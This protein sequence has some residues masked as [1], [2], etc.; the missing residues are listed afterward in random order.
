MLCCTIFS[1]PFGI[2]GCSQRQIFCCCVQHE[3]RMQLC[4]EKKKL[5]VCLDVKCTRKT[6]LCE[7]R[8]LPSC[9]LT[10][11]G[12]GTPKRTKPTTTSV[13]VVMLFPLIHTRVEN[14]TAFHISPKAHPHQ[15]RIRPPIRSGTRNLFVWFFF[16]TNSHH[17]RLVFRDESDLSLV[18][19]GH[20]TCANY[21]PLWTSFCVSV[22]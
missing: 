14:P 2:K 17:I 21:S 20:C 13:S 4:A 1:C 12:C 8:M 6:V 11:N 9:G 19:M 5:F 7:F 18:W 3:Q 16:W 22:M 15:G 10:W